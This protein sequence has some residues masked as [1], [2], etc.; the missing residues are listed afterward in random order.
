[1]AQIVNVV[2]LQEN[3]KIATCMN[4]IVLRLLIL[5]GMIVS[6]TLKIVG[7]IMGAHLTIVMKQKAMIQLRLKMKLL[8]KNGYTVIV[9][10]AIYRTVVTIQV[11]IL[12]AIHTIL[13]VMM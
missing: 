1:M 12:T 6:G 10:M 3:T 13:D 11:N 5:T 8:S 4:I 7:V 9:R 2:T